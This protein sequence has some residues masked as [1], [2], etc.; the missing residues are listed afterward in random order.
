MVIYDYE[1]M[2]NGDLSLSL[3][4]WCY[5]HHDSVNIEKASTT[6]VSFLNENHLNLACKHVPKFTFETN[7]VPK[8]EGYLIYVVLQ[9]GV[10]ILS[11]IWN[12]MY[13]QVKTK[14]MS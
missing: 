14:F 1:Y 7:F 3:R 13:L 10:K 8:G 9:V 2:P 5:L 4:L 11:P 6:N 12:V